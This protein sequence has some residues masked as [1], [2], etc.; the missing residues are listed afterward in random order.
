M[1]DKFNDEQGTRI[2][3]KSHG[4]GSEATRGTDGEPEPDIHKHRSAYGG[5]AGEPK[6]PNEPKQSD[7]PKRGDEPRDIPTSRR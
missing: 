5:N 7:E 2:A 1:P 3:G 6:K 4:S